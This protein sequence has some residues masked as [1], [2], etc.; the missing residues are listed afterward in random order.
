MMMI[1]KSR[2]WIT[3]SNNVTIVSSLV[4]IYILFFFFFYTFMRMG[5]VCTCLC[6]IR[7]D[8]SWRQLLLYRSKNGIICW[9]NACSFVGCPSMM[10]ILGNLHDASFVIFWRNSYTQEFWHNIKRYWMHELDRIPH[11]PCNASFP[12]NS[13]HGNNCNN[14][15]EKNLSK[16]NKR[17]KT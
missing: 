15:K 8:L 12:K 5:I 1:L 3:I 9:V 11:S 4:Y 16:Q 17:K 2:L 7:T 13:L 6:N 14:K 10:I